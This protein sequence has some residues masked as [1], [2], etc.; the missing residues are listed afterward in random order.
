MSLPR[1]SAKSPVYENYFPTVPGN[2]ATLHPGATA[3][4]PAMF[5]AAAA[6]EK[7][8]LVESYIFD[9]DEI[10]RNMLDIMAARAKAGVQVRLILDGFGSERYPFEKL[11]PL[12]AQGGEVYIHKP[13]NLWSK[14]WALLKRLLLL[15]RRFSNSDSRGRD[16]RKMVIIDGRRAFLGGINLTATEK[17]WRDFMIEIEGPAAAGAVRLFT[18]LWNRKNRPLDCP[19]IFPEPKPAGDLAVRILGHQTRNIRRA[20]F[21]AYRDGLGAAKTEIILANAYFLPDR[22]LRRLLFRAVKNGVRV[23]LLLPGKSDVPVAQ[24][25]SE[26]FYH[27]LLRKGIEIYLY[28]AAVLHAKV[29]VVD[30]RWL[31]VGSYNL[32]H[33]SLFDNL[34]VTAVIEDDALGGELRALLAADLGR[35]RKLDLESWA[36]RPWRDKL[37][38]WFFH[39]FAQLM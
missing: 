24:A 12:L 28:D 20:I 33:Q 9:D 16:H 18:G 23:R 5:S 4:F 13:V 30:G 25:A 17:D 11:Q 2:R 8:L 29:A 38:S 21:A 19:G 22:P 10:G 27:R 1:K 34:E 31:T 39:L 6:A 15:S 37:H 35:S 14:G 3:Y 26:Y 7:S 32:D 36:L